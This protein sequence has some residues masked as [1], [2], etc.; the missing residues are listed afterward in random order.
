MSLLAAT[1]LHVRTLNVPG[2]M[3]AVENNRANH[4][5]NRWRARA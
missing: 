5:A 2:F 3:A 4:N 1:I